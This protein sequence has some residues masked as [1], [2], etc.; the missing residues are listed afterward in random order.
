MQSSSDEQND[1]NENE[2]EAEDDDEGCDVSVNTAKAASMADP[3]TTTAE[4]NTE[5]KIDLCK[6]IGDLA[7]RSSGKVYRDPEASE[8]FTSLIYLHNKVNVFL[9]SPT[10]HSFQIF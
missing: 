1:E 9:I 3:S 2:N 7:S 5:P 10:N 4:P 6:V 8:D